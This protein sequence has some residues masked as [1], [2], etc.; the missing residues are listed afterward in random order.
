M[1]QPTGERTETDS[2]GDLNV[3]ADAYWGIQTQRAIENFPISGLRTDPAFVRAYC[4]IKKAAAQTNAELGK[5]DGELAERIVAAADEVLDGD[6]MIK[7]FVV[8]VFQAGAGTSFNMN[9]NEVLTNRVLEGMGN[10]RGD[11]AA[12][13]PNDHVNMSQSTN[14]TFPTAIHLCVR[15]LHEQVDAAVGTLADALAAK[16]R[17][18]A[19]VIKSGRTHLQDAVPVTLGQ[20]FAAHA[21]AIRKCRK[22]LAAAAESM[23]ELALGG[24]ATGTGLNTHPKYRKTVVAKL[25]T[26]TGLPFRPANDPR[27]AM[28]SHVAAA[29]YSAALRGLA[30]ELT[31]LANDLRLL[32]SGPITGFAEIQL[33]A[34]QPG[35]SIMP[36]KVNPV[37][38]ECLNMVAF[39]ILGADHSVSLAA[40]AGQLELNVMMPLMAFELTFCQRLVI[41]YLPVFAEKC[42]VGITADEKACRRYFEISPALATILNPAIGYLNAAKVAKEAVARGVTIRQLVIERQLMTAEEF[43]ALLDPSKITTTADLDAAKD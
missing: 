17:E 23:C 22:N 42:I 16:G 37:M 14:D 15:T 31:R 35:S 13:S 3:S 43:D 12:V 41:N 40:Q 11:Y 30:I 29:A 26:L 33:P 25:A 27:Q 32:S 24:S 19:N 6:A 7:E 1:S 18:F 10:P 28:A 4:L 34:V 39:H 38:A 2:L 5:L 21:E 36:G 8:D 9:V 20:E